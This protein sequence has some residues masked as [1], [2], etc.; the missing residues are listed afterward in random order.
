MKLGTTLRTLE[1]SQGCW[2]ETLTGSFLQ[3]AEVCTFVPSLY[4]MREVMTVM[5]ATLR[6]VPAYVA[7]PQ[8]TRYRWRKLD[9]ERF[10]Q[11]HS[12][13]CSHWRASDY[14]GGPNLLTW[15]D[16]YQEQAT[17][18]YL[19]EIIIGDLLA[20]DRPALSRLICVTLPPPDDAPVLVCAAT[21]ARTGDRRWV[22]PGLLR[23]PGCGQSLVLP[24]SRQKRSALA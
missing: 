7:K 6:K 12:Y 9:G 18:L 21:C 1:S 15:E 11:A 8:F 3:G 19:L 24:A 5:P 23:G 17:V 16:I 14:V 13:Q 20:L 22:G 10:V 4:A 2:N